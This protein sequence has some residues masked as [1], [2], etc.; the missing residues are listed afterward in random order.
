MSALTATLTD[1]QAAFVRA[2]LRTGNVEAAGIAAGYA[3]TRAAYTARNL[4]HVQAAIAAE[5]RRWM[6]T[7][8]AP[9]ALNLLYSVMRDETKDPKLRV[10]CAKTIADR[11]GFIAPKAQASSGLDGK[12]VVDMNRQELIE[13]S[14]RIAKELGDRAGV[15]IDNEPRP[16]VVDPELL[17]IL[18]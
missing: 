11:A 16:P 13:M 2:M 10:A 18:E 7:E 4:P 8:A 9:A 15:T 3:D 17:D 12:S 6:I 1:K 14:Q 5:L